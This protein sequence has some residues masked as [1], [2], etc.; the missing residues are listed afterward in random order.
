MFVSITS[1]PGNDRGPRHMEAVLKSLQHANEQRLPVKLGFTMFEDQVGM[2]CEFPPELRRTV[3]DHLQD[4][5][6]E[7]AFRTMDAVPESRGAFI[8]SVRLSPDVLPILLYT[9]FEDT[10]ERNLADPVTG[11]L[12]AVRVAENKVSR[13][14]ITLTF[15]PCTMRRRKQAQRIAEISQARFAFDWLNDV[16][17]SLATASPLWRRC[18]A[19]PLGWTGIKSPQ[20]SRKPPK[21]DGSLFEC[22]L[23]LRVEAP[24]EKEAAARS[25]L[26]RLA[27][28]FG[29]F[30]HEWPRFAA[31]R[32]KRRA[33][34]GKRGFLLCAGEIATLFHPPVSTV[35]V[36]RMERAGFRELEPPVRLPSKENDYDVTELGR[37]KFRGQRQRFGIRTDDL[38]RHLF[39]CGRTGTGKST[40]LRSM[41]LDGLHSGRNLC[42]IDPHGDLVESVLDAVP[43]HRTNDIVHFS[44]ADRD[45]PVAFNPLRCPHPEQRPLV[46]DGVV[47]GFKKIYGESWGPRLE[48]ILRNSI[49]TLLEQD[50]ATLLSIRRLL[51]SP[52]Y[53][54][55]IAGRV[56]DP[57]VRSFWTDIFASWGERF[58]A[59]AVSPVLN[60]LDGF[61]SNPIARNITCQSRSTLDIRNILDRPKSVLLCNLSKGLVG[62]QT[63]GL[64]GAFLVGAIQTAALSR[65]DIPETQRI[66]VHVYIDEFH[67]FLSEGNDTFATIL[68]E[69][70]KYRVAFAALATQFLEQIDEDTLSAV[71]GNCGSAVVFRSGVRDAEVLAQ[72]L[73]GSIQPDDIVNLPNFTAYAKLLLNGEPTRGAFSMT[74]MPIKPPVSGRRD[75][76]VRV[77]R[78]RYATPKAAAEQEIESAFS[79]TASSKSR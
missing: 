15:R 24:Q 44:A 17:L 46:A 5:Y 63:S 62:E 39:V 33:P 55:S 2:F 22:E 30:A 60:K 32:V 59:E 19:L 66:D 45:W 29:P 6:P 71:L 54:S 57:V 70:R 4:A 28:A 12:S 36:S 52:S 43:K 40:L 58:Q 11:L 53:R 69:S 14:T 56:S 20:G 3:L 65:A 72:H 48:Q 79:A 75:T 77:S 25:Q 18:L 74:T 37:V 47:T 8:R 61:L 35:S 41:I 1:L 64:I 34:D 10:L 21:L 38:R 50:H 7:C 42:V 78:Q 26:A 67:S 49:L 23:T 73:G 51:T 9:A 16:Y 13:S 68:S 27:G 31:G 76:V